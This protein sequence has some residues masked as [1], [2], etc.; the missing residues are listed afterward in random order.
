[1]N[2]LITAGN[3]QTPIDR[4][5][6]ITNTFAGRTGAPIARTAWGRGHTVTFVTSNPD[7]LLEF[8]LN[9]RSPGERFSVLSYQ[10]FDELTS[11][12]HNQLRV[13][14]FDVVCHSATVSDFLAAGTFTPNAGTFF[15]ARTGEWESG[16]GAPTLTEQPAGKIRSAEPELWVRLVRAP[17]L[18]DRIRHPW[19]FTGILVKFELEVDLTEQELVDAAETS[20]TQ[21][22]AD[23]IVANTLDGAAH[24]AYLGPVAGRYERATRREIPD[25]L[26]LALEDL[27]LKRTR[28]G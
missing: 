26:V 24:W 3:T 1:M 14:A 20:R 9:P 8:G 12:L 13:A 7:A 25:R 4:V 21:S 6:C 19:G 2:F 10:T 17:K 23:V 16:T 27:Y 5:R 28:D 11:I 22:G 18:V 15:N